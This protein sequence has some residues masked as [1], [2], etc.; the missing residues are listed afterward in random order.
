MTLND[1]EHPKEG[2]LVFFCDFELW[3]TF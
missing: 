2:F 1:H 3:N